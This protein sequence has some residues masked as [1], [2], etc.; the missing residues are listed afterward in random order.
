[1]AGESFITTVLRVVACSG[2]ATRTP[3][4]ADRGSLNRFGGSGDG[5][6]AIGTPNGAFGSLGNPNG[7]IATD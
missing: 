2:S 7:N 5:A 3:I 6:G 4:A 1:M